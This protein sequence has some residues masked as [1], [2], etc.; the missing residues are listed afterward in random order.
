MK[1]FV[2][3]LVTGLLLAHAS[4]AGAQAAHEERRGDDEYFEFSDDDLLG[5]GLDGYLA[6]IPVRPKPG[7]ALLIRPRVSFV[8]RM[9]QNVES[10]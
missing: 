2:G 7:R 8:Q 4:V 6:R 10:M 9:L 1:L 3:S 5:S